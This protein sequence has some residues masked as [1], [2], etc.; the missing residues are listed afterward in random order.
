[1]EERQEKMYSESYTKNNCTLHLETEI[2]YSQ[3]NFPIFVIK[4]VIS[5]VLAINVPATTNV[6][7]I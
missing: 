7:K 1:M 3:Y 2:N 6:I 5:S 4:F